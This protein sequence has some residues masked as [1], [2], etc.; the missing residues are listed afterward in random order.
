[1]IDW[2]SSD[3]E[4]MQELVFYGIWYLNALTRDIAVGAVNVSATISKD[5]NASQIV[6]GICV[7]D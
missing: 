2:L 5:F 1:M 4:L 7:Y 6:S 3:E